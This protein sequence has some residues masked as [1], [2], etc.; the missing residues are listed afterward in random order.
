MH[1]LM[2][3][4][5]TVTLV[6]AGPGD[7]EL[8][9]LKALKALQSATVI[10]VD[11]LVPTSILALANPEAR[12]VYAGKRGGCQS[13]PQ[14][15]IEKWMVSAAMQG[16]RVVRLKG[17]DPLIFG[18]GGEEVQALQRHGIAV[19]IVNGITSGL[20]AASALQ[21][22][23][24]HRDH[25][26]GVILVT[27]HAKSNSHV[28][29]W[30]ALAQT[31]NHA[32]LTLVIYMGMR[33]VKE[34]QTGLLGGLPHDTPVAVVQNASLPSQRYAVCSLQDLQ[35]CLASHALTSPSVMIVGEVSRGLST[36]G[37][38]MPPSD[39]PDPSGCNGSF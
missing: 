37:T 32:R 30:T 16:E 28:V 13:T 8:L 3:E 29:D 38:V 22:P 17:G 2:S 4:A 31:A 5:G 14:S 7:P 11:D 6:G 26:H 23:F 12:V 24:T 15:Q 35:H 20:A 34:I 36:L 25:A 10:F 39:Y 9:T 19:T 18:R 33:Q 21:I 1:P 27:G